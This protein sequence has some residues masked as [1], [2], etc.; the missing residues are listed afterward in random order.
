MISKNG[1]TPFATNLEE[2]GGVKTIVDKPI[3]RNLWTIMREFNVLPTD[4]RFQAL[5]E[6]QVGF[7]MKNMEKDAEIRTMIARGQDP[8]SHFKD[9]ETEWW[10]VSIDKFDPKGK[11]DISDEEIYAQVEALTSEDDR[12]KLQDISEGNEEWAEYLEEEGNERDRITTESIIQEKL[13]QAQ[14]DARRMTSAGESNWGK[15]RMSEEEEERSDDFKPMTQEGI[16]E[17]YKLF[18]GEEEETTND[19]GPDDSWI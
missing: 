1:W 3:S 7:I 5:T 4:P 15:A 18:E 6:D 11:L 16:E 2:V 13:R 19:L 12:K 9:A 8:N 17:A 14:E 10:D